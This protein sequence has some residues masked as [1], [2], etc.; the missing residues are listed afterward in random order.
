MGLRREH[1]EFVDRLFINGFNRLDAYTAVYPNAN[2]KH[3]EKSAHRLLERSDVKA[4]YNH[5]YKEH[6]KHL[7]IDKE[8]ML[9]MLME[10]LALYEEL[11]LL[12]NKEKLTQTEESRYYR[13]S[14]VLKASDANKTRDMINKII[15]SYAAEKTEVTHKMEQPLFMDPEEQKKLEEPKPDI[16]IKEKKNNDQQGV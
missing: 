1:K 15:G 3:A 9:D 2:P 14:N 12:A 13:L 16:K 5:C 6:R 8:K 11:K 10:E 7:D 4:Y